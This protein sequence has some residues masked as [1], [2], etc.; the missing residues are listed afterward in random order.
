METEGLSKDEKE[1]I[2]LLKAMLERK[3]MITWVKMKY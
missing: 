2:G 3:K 1:D